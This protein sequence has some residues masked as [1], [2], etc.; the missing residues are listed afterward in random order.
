MSANQN[1]QT[2]VTNIGVVANALLPLFRAPSGFGGITIIDCTVTFLTAGTAGLYLVD[3]G[4]AG[5]AT[6]GGT[7]ATRGGTAHTAKTPI[8]MT[9][10][11]G[12]GSYLANNAYLAIKED[13]TGTTV[14]VTQVAVTYRFGK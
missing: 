6:S 7:L 13:N 3:T 9:I 8:A 4:T 11:A 5:T 14:T 12:T 1:P 2:V 10:T